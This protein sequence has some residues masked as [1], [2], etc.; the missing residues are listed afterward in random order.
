MTDGPLMVEEVNVDLELVV[1][2]G[3]GSADSIELGTIAEIYNLL[4]FQN[5]IDT[6]IASSVITLDTI[7]QVRL[8]LGEENTI[9]VNGVIHE[10]KTPSAQQSGLKINVDIPLDSLNVYNLILDFDADESVQETG[11]GYLL[12]PVIK[13]L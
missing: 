11:N 13:V 1:I 7:K 2:K 8:V 3:T 4:D 12:K 5:G 9:K 6:L 10:L